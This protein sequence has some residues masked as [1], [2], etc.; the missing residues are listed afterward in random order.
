MAAPLGGRASWASAVPQ[1]R[2]PPRGEYDLVV[3]HER[4]PHPVPQMGDSHPFP[5][6]RDSHP[7]PKSGSATHF[8]VPR[9]CGTAARL[10]PSPHLP[11]APQR[12]RRTTL[13]M[14][15]QPSPPT[16]CPPAT[17]RT[18]RRCADTLAI[19]PITKALISRS[20]R[21]A[22]AGC[23][24]FPEPAFSIVPRKPRGAAAPVRARPR[25]TRPSSQSSPCPS[26][27]TSKVLL[28]TPQEHDHLEHLDHLSAPGTSASRVPE[29]PRKARYSWHPWHSLAPI[30]G[31][32]GGRPT[33]WLCASSTTRAWVSDYGRAPEAV[34]SATR[35]VSVSCVQWSR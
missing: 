27:P 18:A 5:Q 28:L 15:L 19:H 16:P 10:Q 17:T 13:E 26:R 11:L 20:R 34:A 21:R 3:Q 35:R 29:P 25:C 14:S 24:T 33:S 4:V 32:L 1:A 8:Q 2:P 23:P 12:H 31:Q 6:I 9:N 30:C 22:L 7:F